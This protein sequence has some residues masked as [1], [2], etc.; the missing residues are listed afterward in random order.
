MT[1]TQ[2]IMSVLDD[3]RIT[4]DL[5]EDKRH[6][7]VMEDFLL[8]IHKAGESEKTVHPWIV[9]EEDLLADDW[10]IL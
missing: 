5:W 6:Y 10:S 2:V 3:K 8:Q 4:R 9:A 7:V 1:F